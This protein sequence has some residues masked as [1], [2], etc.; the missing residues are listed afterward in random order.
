M[1]TRLGAGYPER[2]LGEDTQALAHYLQVL[3]EI[4]YHHIGGSDHVVGAETA[5][6]PDWNPYFGKPMLITAES[7][8]PP[9]RRGLARGLT[10]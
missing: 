5:A 7:K 2:L 8:A 1:T 4:G 3:E 10:R 6:R 9:R